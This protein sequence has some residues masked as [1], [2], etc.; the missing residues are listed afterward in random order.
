[1][2]KITAIAAALAGMLALNVQAADAVTGATI[3]VNIQGTEMPKNVDA[4][5]SASVVPK[6]FRQTVKPNG[7]KRG[8]NKVRVLFVVGDPRH[9]SV[10]WDMVNTAMQ[11]FMDKGC[12]VKLRDLYA[13]DWNPILT[14]EN[15]LQAKDGFGKT[16]EDV[17]IEQLYVAAADY[18]IFAYPN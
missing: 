8:T 14:R 3:K 11:H 7:F 6:A 17:A 4:V 1:M 5:T 15:F 9:E 12:E 16:P 13:L 10:E 18:I 2:L